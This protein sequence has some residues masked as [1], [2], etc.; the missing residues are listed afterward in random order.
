MQLVRFI[1]E[2]LQGKKPFCRTAVLI[3]LNGGATMAKQCD[4]CGKIP[5]V[6]NLVSHSN[7]KTK[8]LFN[9]NLQKVRHQCPDGQVLTISA[10]TRCIRSGY[11]LKPL[12]RENS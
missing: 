2:R 4:F 9:P 7:R 8:R 5:Q 10:C 6:G 11:V 12:A 3:N 1:F